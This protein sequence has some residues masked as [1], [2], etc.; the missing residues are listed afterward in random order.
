MEKK[1]DESNSTKKPS[2]KVSVDYIVIVEKHDTQFKCEE[3][4]YSTS[5]KK[6]LQIHI[7]KQ[8]KISGQIDGI[9]DIDLKEDEKH[10]YKETETQTNSP[11]KWGKFCEEI[12]DDTN[13]WKMHMSK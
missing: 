12:F 9:D 8:H 13:A 4:E 5:S 7:V 11:F 6:G 1:L 2:E 10:E 3:C